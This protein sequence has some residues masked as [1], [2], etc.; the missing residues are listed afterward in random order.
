MLNLFTSSVQRE[1]EK[2]RREVTAYIRQDAVMG[3]FFE[4]FMFENLLAKD[5]S[6]LQAYLTEEG[7]LR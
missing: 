3:L 2:E 5:V 7:V 6:A 1:F 4:S